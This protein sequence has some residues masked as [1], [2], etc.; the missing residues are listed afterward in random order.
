M[1]E[2]GA[3]QAKPLLDK[4]LNMHQADRE[5]AKTAIPQVQ[6]D[7]GEGEAP[8]KP[9]GEDSG[10][11]SAMPG[12][13]GNPASGDGPNPATGNGGIAATSFSF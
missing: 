12:G 3:V 13:G 9:L 7:I 8:V 4:D 11:G 5:D 10:I 1:L 6:S 2:K